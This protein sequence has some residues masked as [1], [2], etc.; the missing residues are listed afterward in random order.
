MS[1]GLRPILLLAVALA[2]AAHPFL[3]SISLHLFSAVPEFAELQVLICTAHGAVVIDEQHEVPRPAKDGPSCPWC[4]VA[5]AAAGKLAAITPTVLGLLG[6]EL[7]QHRFERAQCI[8]PHR[9]ADWPAH[10]PRGPP[11]PVTA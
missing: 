4:A 11:R 5:G 7:V 2:V 10:A 9:L 3:R 1:T 8:L 6:P